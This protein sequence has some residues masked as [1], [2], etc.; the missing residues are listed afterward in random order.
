MEDDDGLGCLEDDLFLCEEEMG[1]LGKFGQFTFASP[2]K[3][4]R[5]YLPRETGTE[6]ITSSVCREKATA[7]SLNEPNYLTT[8]VRHDD[9]EAFEQFTP[10]EMITSSHNHISDFN[11]QVK[12]DRPSTLSY[13]DVN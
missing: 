12:E 4:N 8:I 5:S 2:L 1:S 7:R 3:H 6:N 11:L 9:L 10:V 13:Q